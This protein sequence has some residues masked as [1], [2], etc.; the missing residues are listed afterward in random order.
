MIMY[1]F[2]IYN[3]IQIIKSDIVHTVCCRKELGK[4][5]GGLS[6]LKCLPICCSGGV[7][8]ADWYKSST[9]VDIYATFCVIHISLHV[10]H[11]WGTNNKNE[12]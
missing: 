11:K 8:G 1:K 3:C 9:E 4:S 6:G 5:E 7:C 2:Q 10:I 12:V